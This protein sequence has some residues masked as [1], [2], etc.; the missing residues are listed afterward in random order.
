[1]KE[2]YYE[3][4]GVVRGC[5]EEEL[6][7][8]Y[9]K[10][11]V[12]FHPDRNPGDKGAEDR[13]KKVNEAYQILSDPKTRSVYDQF[14]HAGLGGM[15]G[16]GGF[17]QGFGSF[18]DI[19]DNIFGDI[20]GGGQASTGIDLRYN[21]ELTFEEAAFGVEKKINFEKESSCETCSGSGAK[22]GSQ[23]KACKTCRG[24]GQMRFNQGFFTLSRTCSSCS[25]RG[26]VIEEK[27]GS[28]RGRGKSRK[29]HSIVV[30]VPAG[31]DTD[32]RIRL[33]GEGETAEAGGTAGDLYVVIRVKEH[34]LFRR[35]AEHVILEL[36]ITFVQ[37]SLGT[38]LEVPTLQGAAGL[39][40]PAGTQSGT[41]LRLKSK[42]IKRLN[43]S[44]SGDQ[45]IQ[46]LVETPS[47]LTSRQKEI[48]K[49]F[50]KESNENVHPGISTFVKKFK[51]LFGA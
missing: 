2:D 28:C 30:K 16:G 14:G 31:V 10:M 7:K 46:V 1:M 48:L 37:A 26:V 33:R 20:F 11:A 19:F 29:P 27:C 6:K 41:I 13:F 21:L 5:S 44:G 23:P 51:E 3:V 25:G 15:G 43:G 12:Q 9:R 4:L 50:E 32:Q 38:E 18:S 17:E 22:P 39:K 45:I 49:E 36:P 34:S 40:I 8:A 35:E 42:G 24:T 47:H